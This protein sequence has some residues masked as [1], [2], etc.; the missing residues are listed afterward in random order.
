M[1]NFPA[2]HRDIPHTET[3][4]SPTWPLIFQGM[5]HRYGAKSFTYVEYDSNDV[6]DSRIQ[7]TIHFTS[8]EDGIITHQNQLSKPLHPPP[9]NK[10]SND[11][12][13]C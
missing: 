3:N 9:P 2:F 5:P 10:N 4:L 1:N 8:K 13:P 6:L 7:A 12:Y 11:S